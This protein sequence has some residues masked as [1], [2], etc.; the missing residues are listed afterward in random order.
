MSNRASE[1]SRTVRREEAYSDVKLWH[2][3]TVTFWAVAVVR[4]K[5]RKATASILK[6]MCFVGRFLFI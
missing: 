4:Q 5:K 6:K 3:G 2:S 1:R